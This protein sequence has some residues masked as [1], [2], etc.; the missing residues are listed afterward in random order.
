V[1]PS[2]DIHLPERGP[3]MA[4]HR[5]ERHDA[6]TT[7]DE[8]EWSADRDVPDEVP[9]DRPPQLEP[10]P[11]TQLLGEIGRD[12]ALVQAIDRQ[13]D[14]RVFW[15]RG[16]GIAPLCLVAVLRREAH[17]HVLARAVAG[18]ARDVKDKGPRPQRGGGRGA[19]VRRGL[20]HSSPAY[21]CSRHGSP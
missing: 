5:H 4:Q 3:P 21:R 1:V 20:V 7:P 8:E 17:V 18:P 15:R 9:A 19:G 13:R 6:G 11:H 12:L 10:V 14:P 16:D 2:L